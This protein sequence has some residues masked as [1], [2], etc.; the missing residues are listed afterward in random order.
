MSFLQSASDPRKKEKSF[1][2]G[3]IFTQKKLVLSPKLKQI[4]QF[5]TGKLE[6][7]PRLVNP[8]LYNFH[9]MTRIF[10]GFTVWKYL[11][12]VAIKLHL[13]MEKLH[14]SNV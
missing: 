7:C 9:Q 8:A 1:F 6:N 11:V 2:R 10:L 5:H 13:S 3:P 12:Q 4:D 14:Y